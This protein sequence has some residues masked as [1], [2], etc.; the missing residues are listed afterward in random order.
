MGL[1]DELAHALIQ[2]YREEIDPAVITDA[3]AFF[4]SQTDLDPLLLTFATDFPVAS[5]YQG[6]E[7]P[8]DWLAAST[9]GTPNREIAF[10]ELLL[11]HLANRNPAYTP[12]KL[13]FNDQAL[14]QAPYQTVAQS[15]PTYFHSRPELPQLGTLLDALI[16]PILADPT[17][18][19]AQLDFIREKWAAL[20]G[21][22]FTAA[23]LRRTLLALASVR[24]EEVALWLRHHP[25]DPNA[26]QFQG[27]GKNTHGFIGDEYVGFE[28]D[29]ETAPDGTR[30]RRY[31][32]DY[33][34][35]LNEYEAFSA[36]HAWMP[37]VILIAKSTYVWLEQLSKQYQRH[38]HRLDQIPTEELQTLADRG[39]T[40]LWLIGL[41]ERSR[42]SQ[43]IKRLCGNPD[44][45]ASAYSLKS[46]TIA[47]DLG[48]EQAYQDLRDR[49][50]RCGLRLASDMVPNHMG[51]DSDWVLD[52]PDLF[53][54]RPESPFPVYTFEGPN[55]SDD[56]RVEIKL[57]DHYYNRSDAAVVFRLRTHSNNQ[58][59]FVYH[60]KRRHHLRLERH[61]PARLLQSRRPRAR[62]AGH[63]R[64]RP[65]LSPSS[66]STPPWSSPSAT[67]SA[68]GSPPRRRRLHPL[69]RRR[70]HLRGAVRSPH[71]PRILARGR[72]PR[73]RRGPRNPPPRRSLLA[74]RGLLRPHSRHAPR[75]QL[76]LHEHAAR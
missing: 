9:D 18:I 21:D 2:R 75:L 23:I 59:R 48:G 66:V 11:L 61:R 6:F 24:E 57:E 14:P 26:P 68:S 73:R 41:W 46:Y 42:A 52:R 51:I 67:S 56:P 76:R 50:A 53:I 54:S 5:V 20:L 58:T 30:R 65:P 19:T 15:L 71:A 35:P 12:F 55:L 47:Q 69:T 32:A 4:S 34:A 45:V 70:R 40:G 1:I 60:G 62:H 13:L 72:R 7:S 33:Q 25:A 49:A 44:A 28:N 10:E 64:R 3:L 16:A 8:A 22:E 74:P 38:I 43:T 39:I 27:H 17:S 37:N 29:F 31:S 63:P 36:D